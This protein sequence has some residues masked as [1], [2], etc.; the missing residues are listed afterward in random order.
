M[1]LLRKFTRQALWFSLVWLAVAA[2]QAFAAKP[3]MA[4]VPDD[5]A[6]VCPI[7]VGQT[8]PDL[9]AKDIAGKPVDVNAVFAKKPTLLIFYRGSWCPYC[10][11]HLG[12]LKTI[13]DE[14]TKL[15]YQVVAVS[16][17]LPKNLKK[18]VKQNDL[19]YQLISDSKA[20]IAQKLG[21]A[22]KVD[23]ETFEMLQGYDI[24][25]EKASGETHRILPVPAAILLDQSGKVEFTFFSPDYKVR[26]NKHVLLAAAK[27]SA[28]KQ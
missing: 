1:N 7:K 24:D 6:N 8:V 26:I 25:I 5:A 27:S 18:S 23:Q 19:S 3:K 10:N 2:T 16:P 4:M 21:L 22:F 9:M 13:E 11:T 28:K 17:D 15:G 12:E 14:L 20:E